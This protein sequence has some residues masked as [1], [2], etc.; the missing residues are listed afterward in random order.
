MKNRLSILALS[1][2][3]A[4]LAAAGAASAQHR[5]HHHGPRVTFGL[6][7]GV[8]IGGYYAPSY[9]YYPYFPYPHYAYPYPPYAYPAP[10][11]VQQP[12][13]V[14]IE[15]EPAPQVQQPTGYW[16]YCADAR[17]YYPY[18]R[19]CPGGWQRVSPQPG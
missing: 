18:V 17:A 3:L 13:T 10:I 9:S 16:Y 2:A 6:H 11:V 4:G 7:I 19:E 12:P 5:H 1:L 14:Y 8:P 15:Q